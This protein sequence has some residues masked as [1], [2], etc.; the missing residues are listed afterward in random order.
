[1][2]AV[3]SVGLVV[4]GAEVDMVTEGDWSAAMFDHVALD[5]NC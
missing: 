5:R 2:T 4:P 1:M 3:T